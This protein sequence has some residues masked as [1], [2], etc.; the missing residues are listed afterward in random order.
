MWGTEVWQGLQGHMQFCLF[1]EIFSGC[2][3]DGVGTVMFLKHK[4]T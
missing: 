1:L 4:E 2:I 3:E